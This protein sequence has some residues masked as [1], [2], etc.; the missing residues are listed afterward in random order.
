MHEIMFLGNFVHWDEDSSIVRHCRGSARIGFEEEDDGRALTQK[1]LGAFDEYHAETFFNRSAAAQLVL[2]HLHEFSSWWAKHRSSNLSEVIDLLR[3]KP[4]D[5]PTMMPQD[6]DEWCR[7]KLPC[8]RS[9]IEVVDAL[10]TNNHKELWQTCD[11]VVTPL[12][13]PATPHIL[14][15]I[16]SRKMLVPVVNQMA[17]FLAPLVEKSWSVSPADQ[18]IRD[19][20]R[21]IAEFGM[22][23]LSELLPSGISIYLRPCRVDDQHAGYAIL[24]R[25]T[26][27]LKR[28][29]K[30]SGQVQESGRRRELDVLAEY[31]G[32]VMLKK[33]TTV[34]AFLGSIVLTENGVE[35]G[36]LD[37]VLVEFLPTEVVWRFL[38]VKE[39]KRCNTKANHQVANLKLLFGHN[40]QLTSDE[41]FSSKLVGKVKSLTFSWKGEKV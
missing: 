15:D 32:S 39:S 20:W 18:A 26:G 14:I 29:K 12:P 8:D 3:K 40:S 2:A 37:G 23:L 21:S 6:L 28:L 38:E 33:K 36:E 22:S 16:Y 27:S 34:L 17:S 19:L 11:F 5:W 10:L 41:D 13:N 31:W 1:M 25:N 30:V 9:W 7:L 35:I 4:D 24:G